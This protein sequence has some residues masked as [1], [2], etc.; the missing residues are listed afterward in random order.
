MKNPSPALTRGADVTLTDQ[1]TARFSER[2]RQ[3]L[4]APGSRLPSVR[5]CARHHGV[6]AYTV[7]AAYDQLQAQGLV[8][9]RRQRGFYVRHT[10]PEARTAAKAPPHAPLPISAT[11]LVRGMFQAPGTLPMPGLGTLPIEWLDLPMLASALRR[12][13]SGPLL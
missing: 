6:S 1:L 5:E 10:L 11:T 13:A 7:V 8:E 3:R 2:I 12:V 4:L 9:A